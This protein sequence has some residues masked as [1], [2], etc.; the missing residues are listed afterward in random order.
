MADTIQDSAETWSDWIAAEEEATCE[1]YRRNP[2]RLIS[3]AGQEASATNDYA[4]RELLE[5]LQN[6]GDAATDAGIEGRVRIELTETG[7]LVANTGKPFSRDGVASLRVAHLSPKRRAKFVGNK[8][9][10][11]RAVLNWSR[12][13]C[14]LS[15]NLQLAYSFK[16]ARQKQD[17]LVTGGGDV[18]QVILQEL[19]TQES[20][21]LPLLAFPVCPRDQNLEPLFDSEEQRLLFLSARKIRDR[22]DTVVSMP[23]DDREGGFRNAKAQIEQLRPEVL[24]FASGLSEISITLPGEPERTWTKQPVEN[25]LVRISISGG[26]EPILA[27]HVRREMK[28]V[29]AEFLPPDSPPLDYEVAIAT[30]SN[31]S[32][33][34]GFLYSYFPTEVRF[35]YAVIAHATVELLSNR[36]QFKPTKANEFIISRLANLLAK[37][38]AERAA[39]AA[40]CSGLEILSP[41]AHHGEALSKIGFREMLMTHAREL[42]LI[43]VR[44]GHLVRA[45]EALHASFE[46]TSWLPA[47]AFPTVVDTRKGGSIKEVLGQL[48]VPSLE[49]EHWQQARELLEFHTIDERA[50]FIVGSLKH[51]AESA[52]SLPLLLDGFGSPVPAGRRVFVSG[53]NERLHDVPEWVDLRFLDQNL[54]KAL[55][56]RLNVGDQIALVG[57]LAPLGVVRYSLDNVLSHLVARANQR[58]SETPAE[59]ATIRR[60]LLRVLYSLY[61]EDQSPGERPKFP[62]DAGL[63]LLTKA[64]TFRSAKA[65]YLSGG[66]GPKGRILEGLYRNFPERLLAEPG[67]LGF[68]E[69]GPTYDQ[70]F[71]WLGVAEFPREDIET[72]PGHDFREYVLASLSF[73]IRMQDD[74]IERATS[75]NSV[76]FS[77]LATVDGLNDILST[78]NP[79]AILSWLAHDER[80]KSWKIPSTAHGRLENR[81]HRASVHRHYEGPIPS[82]VRWR[83]QS[84]TWLPLRDGTPARPMDCVVEVAHGLEELFPTPARP[85]Q[86]Q[87]AEFDLP[88]ALIRDAHDRAGVIS[89]F[90]QID[91]DQ[92][93][94]MLL[95]LPEREGDRQGRWA[96]G[97]YRAVLDHFSSAD[98]TDSPA[99][100]RFC[101][102]GRMWARQAEVETYCKVSD[103]WNVDSEDVPVA[104]LKNLNVAALPKRSGS[105]KVFDLFG[106]RSVDRKN[107]LRTISD[108]QPVVGAEQ[109]NAEI[110]SIKPMIFFLRRS[111]SQSARETDLFK[112]VT[113]QVCLSISGEVEFEGQQ[114]PLELGAWDWILDENSKTAYV[115]TD[116]SEPDPLRSDLLADAVGQIFAAIFSVERGDEFARLIACKPKNRVK[117]LRRLAGEEDL[118][119]IA[120]I[121]RRYLNATTSREPQEIKVPDEPPKQPHTSKP[122]PPPTL[123]PIQPPAPEDPALGDQPLKIEKREHEPIERSRIGCR[124]TRKQTGG[125]RN[126]SG[127]R[128]VTN[129]AF[130]EKKA[131]EFEE[132]DSPARFPILVSNVTGWQAPGVDIISFASVEDRANFNA[133]PVKNDGLIARFIEVKGTA[134]GNSKV[135]LRGNELTAA[136]LQR[137]RYYIYSVFDRGD[138]N[139]SLAILQDPL[140]DSKGV[141]AVVEVDLEVAAGTVE[142]E[143]SGGLQESNFV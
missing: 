132:N 119:T 118:P 103:L 38:A 31:L 104:L 136:Q 12:F 143:M 120:E 48:E 72:E 29:P 111:R 14:I 17:D 116:P 112:S 35:P 22:F 49:E 134:S 95:T 57:R 36:Q 1:E 43:P 97:V 127:T 74:V 16:F 96:R 26:E 25:G 77:K 122:D 126:L 93:Y 106:V 125:Q 124:V 13:P 41:K 23:F 21:L 30:A 102:Q 70:F 121:E 133:S 140:G 138:G 71:L 51:A 10:G 105:K 79:I 113:I 11:F 83:L 8:G 137:G 3:D 19:R 142:F 9:L 101:R 64:G 54:R 117:I 73:P 20:L 28:S 62:A 7:L 66:Y 45:D 109:F 52:F 69:S 65:V 34:A 141:R 50:D 90:T 46:D 42:A 80:A 61:P 60:E 76:R 139:Y 37:C 18:A 68:D 114:S 24:L 6:A 5:L 58:V 123:P 67:A 15:G 128:R 2:R 108:H 115:Q 33:E 32:S 81:P 44:A 92:L 110:Q 63:Q 40:D 53:P 86:D 47:T 55:E 27:W 135:D 87:L 100:Q 107:I 98:V 39:A 75:L 4:G 89:S 82:Y 129:W 131:M 91:P 56:S 88:G 85:T 130:C 84:S 99:R 94:S 78:G 59:E